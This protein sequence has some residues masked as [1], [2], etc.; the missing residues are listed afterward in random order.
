MRTLPISLVFLFIIFIQPLAARGPEIPG[1]I[2]RISFGSCY[3]QGAESPIW[4][5]IAGGAPDLFL[6]LGDVVYADTA[7]PGRMKDAYNTLD[8]EPAFS[9]FRQRVPLLGVWDDHDYGLNDGGG[10]FVGKVASRNAFLNF[11]HEPE[12]SIRRSR[13]GIYQSYELGPADRRIQLILLDT[14]F[15]RSPHGKPGWFSWWFKSKVVNRDPGATILGEEQWNWL[16]G[17]LKKP[18]VFRIIASSIQVLADD[19]PYESWSRF[20]GER[21][22]LME[23]LRKTGAQGV[24]FLSGD[25]HFAEIVRRQEPGLYPLYD[26]TSSG[27]THFYEGA[28]G[29]KETGRVSAFAGMNYG[30]LWFDWK[31]DPEIRFRILD[32]EGQLQSEVRVKR[33]RLTF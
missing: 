5:R 13:S 14:R 26:F 32:G 8:R 3:H 19:H 33:S 11:L 10:D 2:S 17:E 16:E 29:T 20:P 12:T 24:V 21:E 4:D 23:L 6:F 31:G 28:L 1:S 15:N 27:L 9:R 7:D 25:R 22:R 18:A 30:E